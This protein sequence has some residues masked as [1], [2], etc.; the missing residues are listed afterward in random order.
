MRKATLFNV[1]KNM[2]LLLVSMMMIGGV[3]QLHA[4]DDCPPLT[5]FCQDLHTSFM[6]DLCM[7]DVW[8]KDFVSKINTPDTDIN[9]FI[10]SFD[11]DGDE[12]NQ[13]YESQHGTSFEVPIFITNPCNG[14]QTQC[15]VNLDIQDNTGLCPTEPC[16]VDP[17]PWCGFGVVTCTT[18][19]GTPEELTGQVAALVDIRKN[20]QAPRGDNWSNPLTAGADDIEVVRPPSWNIAR[21]GNI[22]GIAMNP[23]NGDIFFAASDIYDFDFQQFV[24]IGPPPPA[25]TGPA[26]SAGIYTVNFNNINTVRNLTLT[27]SNYTTASN[28]IGTRRIPNTGNDATPANSGNGIG[29]IDFDLN[30]ENLFVSNLEDGILYSINSTTGVVEDVF[31]PFGQYVHS[32]DIAGIVEI[33]ERIWGLAVSDCSATSRLFFA[34]NSTAEDTTEDANEPKGVY[35][36]GLNSDGTFQNDLRVEF[37]DNTGDMSKLTDLSF[38]ADCDQILIAE[39]GDPHSS[40]TNR[41][42][43]VNGVW[44]FERQYYT[45]IVSGPNT[46]R[47]FGNST[48]GGVA[49]APT[50]QGCV[51][52]SEC[53]GLAYSTINCGEIIADDA[54]PPMFDCAV[55][56]IQGADE[57]GNAGGTSNQTDI[58]VGIVEADVDSDVFRFKSNIGDVEIFNC[59]CPKEVGRNVINQGMSAI[60]AGEILT[61]ERSLVAGTEV[62]LSIENPMLQTMTTEDGQYLFE[63]LEMHHNYDI[64]PAKSADMIDG[65]ST[66]DLILIQRH[67]LG[68]QP[69][70]SA[71]KKIAA[72]VN[73]DSRI[74]ATD[75]ALLRRILLGMAETPE[76][77]SWTFVPEN[78]VFE[79][80]SN[81][82]SYPTSIRIRDLESNQMHENFIAIKK[83]DVNGDNSYNLRAAARSNEQV[84]INFEISDGIV[85]VLVNQSIDMRGFQMEL[86][87]EGLSGVPFNFESDILNLESGNISTTSSTVRLSWNSS[88]PLR[89]TESN[90]L[91][92]FEISGE[93]IDVAVGKSSFTSEL[94]TE[95]LEALPIVQGDQHLTTNTALY[96]N[97]PNPFDNSTTISFFLEKDDMVLIEFFDMSGRM[98]HSENKNYGKG[99]GK[100]V[101]DA[102]LY[103]AAKEQ[104]IFYSL[105]TADF[106]ET[107]KMISIQN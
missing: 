52:D 90:V 13:I 106:S 74:S 80:L 17:N 47:T 5:V 63:N 12:M 25:V 79:N 101:F 2:I 42:D 83:G 40:E 21:M 58:Y 105:T 70:P 8:A 72:D 44:T 39:R 104:V 41:Y 35:S 93:N 4:Q 86:D 33:S 43:L 14:E 57:A 20:S 36:V 7:V 28:A 56:G 64:L 38:N 22:F 30:S 85:Y 23:R 78:F 34:R 54:D 11:P 65:V 76:E 89:L 55:Y 97:S 103:G 29:N 67:V 53:D 61:E 27:N 48:A 31:D 19:Q 69:L 51:I 24:T 71:Y 96:G 91:L 87:I 82:F 88:T 84:K 15:L 46:S 98:I 9:D 62:T 75:L 10:I 49:W 99:F 6:P 59:C 94:Y 32:D 107:K 26:G 102:S 95:D 18:I 3:G 100:Y 66:L 60:I 68:L 81:P 73:N 37:I 50:E 92:S 16:P 45:G 1:Q 77:D